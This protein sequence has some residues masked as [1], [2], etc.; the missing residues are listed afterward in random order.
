MNRNIFTGIIILIIVAVA[1]F[2]KPAKTE[3]HEWMINDYAYV[4]HVCS[5][6]EP[7]IASA[8]LYKDPTKENI[9]KAD[10]MFLEAMTAKICIFNPQ[11]WLVRLT[12]KVFTVQDLYGIEGYDGMVWSVTTV[13]QNGLV[14]QVYVGMLK[15]EYASKKPISNFLGNNI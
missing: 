1:F 15:K 7:L 4:T 8:L 10:K 14:Y 6:P 3:E 12:E 2:V 13:G 9:A 11:D 5:T